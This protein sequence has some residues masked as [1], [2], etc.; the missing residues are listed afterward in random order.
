MS[1]E[2]SFPR[3]AIVGMLH[4]PA[5]PGAP[6]ARLSIAE[7]EQW[8]LRDA[9]ALAA[10]GVD[11]L[12]LENFG[13]APF[14]PDQVPSHTV[15]YITRI[16]QAVRSRFSLPLGIN[17]LR[18][19]ARAALAI[20]A[21]VGAQFI[22][23]NIL[24]GARL[25]DQGLIQGQAHVLLR[26]RLLLN[27]HLAIWADVAVKHSVPLA[28]RP[29]EEEIEDTLKRAHAS[30]IIVSGA[31]TGKA[32]PIDRLRAAKLAAAAAPVYVGSGVHLDTVAEV[33]RI[34]DG[35]IVGSAL[36]RDGI[37]ANPVDPE[38]VRSFVAAAR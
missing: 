21:A 8:A 16:A 6:A 9:D 26:D 25:T 10:G 20:A 34:A 14:F 19:D 13:D 32:T 37:A 31:A 28:D 24:T 29:L 4:L 23:V 22:R 38:R 5:L 12:L 7:I 2:I 3:K 36:K 11:A 15:A 17:V 30:A 18:N 27:A 33:L 1:A 35:V